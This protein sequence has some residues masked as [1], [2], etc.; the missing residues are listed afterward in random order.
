MTAHK[1]AAELL[2][3]HVTPGDTLLDVGCGGGYFYHSIRERRINVAYHGIDSAPSL[4]AIGRQILPGYGLAAER[5]T[6]MRIE[7]LHA[8]V[9]HVICVN[10][11]S[12]VDNYHRPLERMLL[13]A[14][15][16]VILRESIA[17]VNKYDYVEDRYLD[18]GVH[19]RVHI[20]TY[21]RQDIARFIEDYGFRVA[22]HVDE[23]TGGTPQNVIDHPHSWTFVEA[24]RTRSRDV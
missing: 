2:A 23:F 15:K 4:I 7:D 17:D 10:V 21:D 16:T 14:R 3:P 13:A 9:D 11:L 6:H 1:Q 18:P 8:D 5:L 12:N 24:V 20:N 19:L 22:F